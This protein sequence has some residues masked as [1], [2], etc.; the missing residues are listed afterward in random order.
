MALASPELAG[1]H[2]T[3]STAVF[4]SIWAGVGANMSNYRT[5]PRLVGETGGKGFVLAHPSADV[6]ALA[7]ALVRAAFEFQGQK[8]SAASRALTYMQVKD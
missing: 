7:I 1:V 5:F 8:C 4:R 3:G 2:Y 6:E